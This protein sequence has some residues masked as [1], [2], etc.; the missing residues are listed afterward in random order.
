M[1]IPKNN[2]QN[3]V[4]FVKFQVFQKVLALKVARKFGKLELKKPSPASSLAS[5]ETSY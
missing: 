2:V 5:L 1:P 4:V 3:W